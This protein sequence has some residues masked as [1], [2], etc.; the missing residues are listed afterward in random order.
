MTRDGHFGL[1]FSVELQFVASAISRGADC[2]EGLH[3]VG[4]RLP[5]EC[6]HVRRKADIPNIGCVL[7]GVLRDRNDLKLLTGCADDIPNSFAQQK[8]CYWG[9]EGNR[10]GLWV[11]FVLSHDTI[12]LYAPIVTL[13]GHRAPKG[14]SV[15]RR[16][17]GDDLS[18]PNSRRKV[19]R[20]TQGVCCLPPSFIHVF[21]LL[22]PLVCLA[23]LVELIFRS[24]Y[25]PSIT[26]FG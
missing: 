4:S 5:Q 19:A 25:P 18:R 1:P 3:W 9:Y 14:N 2:W 6:P 22:R 23:S 20:I 21:D 11:R 13:E 17:I 8:P 10:T 26:R 24:F 12:F 16:R 7:C 15:S